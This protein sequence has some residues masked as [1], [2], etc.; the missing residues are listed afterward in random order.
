VSG[1]A[2]TRIGR[3]ADAV[4]ARLSRSYRRALERTLAGPRKVVAVLAVLFEISLPLYTQV[5]VAFFPRTDASQFMINLKAQSGTRLEITESQVR[6]VEGLIRQAVAPAD[7]DVILSNIGVTP[8]F[9]SIYTSNSAQHT[10][11]IQVNLRE[12]H[13]TGSYEYMASLRDRLR[14]AMPQLTA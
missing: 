14:A 2:V 9:S 10:A 6:S 8:G 12:D 7:L 1:H 4:F 3:Q 5:R 11:F 13:K